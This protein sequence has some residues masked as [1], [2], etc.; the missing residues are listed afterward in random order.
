MLVLVKTYAWCFHFRFFNLEV[1]YLFCAVPC[2]YSLHF[3][4]H[5]FLV[6]LRVLPV[7]LGSLDSVISR[8]H[9]AFM[10]MDMRNQLKVGTRKCV[11]LED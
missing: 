6:C 7:L 2:K 11:F 9:Q 1:S 3:I 4:L 8:L 10:Y 5:F